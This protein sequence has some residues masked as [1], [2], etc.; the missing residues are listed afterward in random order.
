M[1]KIP[2][3]IVLGDKEVENGEVAVRDRKGDLG[4]MKLEDFVA[5]LKEEVD[6]KAL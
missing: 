6:T 5:K 4:T 1:Q 3:M 2:Y